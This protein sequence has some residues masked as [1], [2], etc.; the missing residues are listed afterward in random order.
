MR[1][2]VLVAITL[3]AAV[4]LQAQDAPTLLARGDSAA[5]AS[6]HREAIDRYEAALALAPELRKSVLHR[7]VM[8]LGS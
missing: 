4:E 8:Q 2:A 6:Q 7:P 1:A 5:W 3:I